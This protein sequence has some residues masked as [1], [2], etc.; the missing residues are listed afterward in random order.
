MHDL[1]TFLDERRGPAKPEWNPSVLN[2]QSEFMTVRKM[3]VNAY[4]EYPVYVVEEAFTKKF[5]DHL[6]DQF[7][8]QEQHPVGVDGFCDP[9]NNVGSYRANAWATELQKVMSDKL[10]K[11]MSEKVF[12]PYNEYSMHELKAD[13][14]NRFSTPFNI[15]ILNKGKKLELL[16]STSWMRFMKYADGGMH[17]PH[18]DAPFTNYMEK[19]ITLFS[20]VLYLNSPDG[21]QG[22]FQFVDDRKQK[23]HPPAMWN[24]SDWTNMSTELSLC[25]GAKQGRLLIFPHWLCHQVEEF[26]GNGHRYIIRGD[27]AYGY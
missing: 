1:T 12:V 26:V 4:D 11:I 14:G 18:H 7:D 21:I 15:G 2:P 24:T 16:G 17:T 22:N 5:C 25:V 3:G 27:V 6:I 23:G 13:N 9:A 19:Y 8:N 20:W 10:K